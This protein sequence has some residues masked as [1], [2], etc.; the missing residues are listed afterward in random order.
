MHTHIHTHTHTHMGRQ[1][2]V[3]IAYHNFL[4]SVC[5]LSQGKRREVAL[6]VE[7][8]YHD[9]LLLLCECVFMQINRCYVNVE[10]TE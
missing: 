8:K 10:L 3:Y 9:L 6:T 7:V 1:L 4:V 2:S 5:T